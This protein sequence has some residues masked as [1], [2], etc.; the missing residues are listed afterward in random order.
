MLVECQKLK[1]FPDGYPESTDC[2]FISSPALRKLADGDKKEGLARIPATVKRLDL[3]VSRLGEIGSGWFEHLVELRVLNLEFNNLK[4]IPAY[5]FRGLSKLKVLWLTGN[6]YSRDEEEFDRMQRAGNTIKSIADE[7]FVGLV[8]L[9]VLLMHHNKID[10]LGNVIFQDLA[11]L[12]V[13]KLLDNP[14]AT[15]LKKERQDL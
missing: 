11:K 5:A 2:V 13:L 14:V 8:N 7:A 15:E 10:A 4:S 6:H 3:A 12:K 9:Q 1:K